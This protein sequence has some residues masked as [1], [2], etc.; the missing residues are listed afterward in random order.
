MLILKWG[1]GFSALM[2][3]ALIEEGIE[4]E[5]VEMSEREM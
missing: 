1:H 2:L 4:F 3:R 5:E